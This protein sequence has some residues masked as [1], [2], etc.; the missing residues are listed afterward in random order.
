[1]N[2]YTAGKGNQQVKLAVDISTNGFAW[3]RG[4]TITEDG[5]K[6]PIPKCVSDATGD[7]RQMP[8]GRAAGLQGRYIHVVTKI[9]LF[10]E[11]IATRKMEFEKISARYVFDNGEEGHREFTVP[12]QKINANGDFTIVYLLI[13]IKQD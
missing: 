11:E 12:D 2:H 7:I 1:M 6:L 10:W 9:E 8:V 13:T 5:A 4:F 3:T